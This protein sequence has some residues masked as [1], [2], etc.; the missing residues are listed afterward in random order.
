MMLSPEKFNEPFKPYIVYNGKRSM[1]PSDLKEDEILFLSQIVGE[2]DNYWLKARVSNIT[3]LLL[4]PR[5]VSFALE[6]IDSYVQAPL[7]KDNL[8][9]DGR[10]CWKRAIYLC[11]NLRKGSGD[12][13]EKI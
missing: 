4:R 9:R 3:W 5:D 11:R 7:D 6:A 1:I 8:V 2:I 12:R 10:E 13:L